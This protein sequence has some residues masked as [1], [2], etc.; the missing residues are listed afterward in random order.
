[1]PRLS[2]SMEEG[3]ILK[4]LVDDGAE[5]A[6]GDELVEVET[7]KATMTYEADAAG[8]ITLV[9]KEGDTLAVGAVIARF[10]G[11]T[12]NPAPAPVSPAA[13][14][15]VPAAAA[16]QRTA[17]PPPVASTDRVAASP[18]ARRVA[19]KMGIDLAALTG[20]GPGGRVVK[21]D[22]EAVSN[23]AAAPAP[24]APPAQSGSAKGDVKVV[25]LSRLQQVVARRMAES[26]ALVPEFTL[27]TEI[28]MSACV[29]LRTQLK[30]M[31]LKVSFNDMVIKACALALREHPRANGSYRD[32]RFELYGRVNVGMAVA[33]D[34]A[35]VVP[36]IFDADTR[37]LGTIATTTATLAARVRSGE[38]TP[39]ELSGGTFT[40][41]NLG[42]FGVTDFT[43]IINAP[44]AAI[45]AVGAMVK[46]PVVCDNEIVVRP[47]MPVTLTSDHRILYGADAA[48]FLATIRTKLEHPV[49][50]LT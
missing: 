27:T 5:V 46:K 29:D 47:V 9:G 32:E 43:A 3:T 13:A 23:G 38:V 19:A 6:R 10:G 26:K 15:P 2:D 8:L 31:E 41:S 40:V 20:S 33:A 18:I 12:P 44:Q 16:P 45:L 11:D 36:T 50:L 37:S 49:A 28:D 21:A 7:D 22:V 24:A 39:P 30:E 48:E 35:L 14:A 34:D 25:E 1:M 17:E 42:M 4:W